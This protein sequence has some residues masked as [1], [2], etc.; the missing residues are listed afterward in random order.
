M[1]RKLIGACRTGEVRDA[2]ADRMLAAASPRQ[3][4]FAQRTS[5]A[6]FHIDAV[7]PQFASDNS[8]WP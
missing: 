2:L 4:G 1:L 5:E 7:P 3:R 6:P 8:A